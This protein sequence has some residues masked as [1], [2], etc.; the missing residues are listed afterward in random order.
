MAS[1]IDTQVSQNYTTQTIVLESIGEDVNLEDSNI[2]DADNSNNDNKKIAEGPKIPRKKPMIEVSVPI[3]SVSPREINLTNI[4]T[5][6]S[7][8]EEGY[9]SD[10]NAGPWCEMEELEG[11]QDFEE[12]DLREMENFYDLFEEEEEGTKVGSSID[13]NDN[14]LHQML[15]K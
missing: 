8:F 11:I 7:R 13:I 9:N 4:Y 15:G 5:N 6:E 10:G 1:L 12:A 2:E 3:D 14:V